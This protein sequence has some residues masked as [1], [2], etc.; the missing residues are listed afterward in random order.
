MNS[1]GIFR[2]KDTDL[3]FVAE[4]YD[5]EPGL[6]VVLPASFPQQHLLALNRIQQPLSPSKALNCEQ[7]SKSL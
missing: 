7:I 5:L 1:S 3:C 2:E 4:V 6:S